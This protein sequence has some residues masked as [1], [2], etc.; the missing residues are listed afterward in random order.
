MNVFEF[1]GLIVL[2]LAFA[3]FCSCPSYPF[4]ASKLGSVRPRDTQ[5]TMRPSPLPE[6][7]PTFAPRCHVIDCF[8]LASLD[9][10]SIG[11]TLTFQRI[12]QAFFVCSIV[13]FSF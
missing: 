4:P 7:P 5:G 8:P 3:V 13:S 6:S 12:N 2:I 10:I 11:R 9:Y 1:E